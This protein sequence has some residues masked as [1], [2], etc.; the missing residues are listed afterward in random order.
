MGMWPHRWTIRAAGGLQAAAG[1]VT[2][3]LSQGRF[4]FYRRIVLP[5]CEFIN[6]AWLTVGFLQI[7]L[8]FL[9]PAVDNPARVES[10]GLDECCAKV[11]LG[12]GENSTNVHSRL[13]Q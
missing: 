10:P 7:P 8:R 4:D 5:E 2:S 13:M 12:V 11:D 3:F 1:I 6:L 9:G